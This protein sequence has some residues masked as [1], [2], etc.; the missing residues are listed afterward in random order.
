MIFLVA[1][2][3][4]IANIRWLQLGDRDKLRTVPVV[5]TLVLILAVVILQGFLSIFDWVIVLVYL[6][7]FAASFYYTAHHSLKWNL[8]LMVTSLVF[9]FCMEYIGG[10]QGL[11]T[12]RFQAPVSV[13]ILFSWPLRVWAVNALCYIV[14]ID[15]SKHFGKPAIETKQ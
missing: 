14:G 15:F 10:I 13:L 4:F 3:K 12:F 9:G 5:V 6:L 2:S 1:A 8:L 11:W 7:L